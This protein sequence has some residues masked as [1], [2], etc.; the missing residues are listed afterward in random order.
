MDLVRQTIEDVIDNNTIDPIE[1]TIE[2]VI[3]DYKIDPIEQTIEEVIVKYSGKVTKR[4]NVGPKK[5]NV[6]KAALNQW[7]NEL[8]SETKYRKKQGT[9]LTVQCL[10]GNE[11]SGE[12]KDPVV[13]GATLIVSP[14]SICDQ[15]VSEVRKHIIDKD[16][17]VMVYGGIFGSLKTRFPTES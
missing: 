9:N 1:Q 10:C 2:E 5:I 16:F 8:L 13:S 15:W 4:K 6:H 12:K 17:K 3:S 11:K 7:Y 14:D